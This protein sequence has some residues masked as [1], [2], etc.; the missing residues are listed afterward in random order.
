MLLW[1]GG[2]V[3]GWVIAVVGIY[4]LVRTGDVLLA[5]LFRL[6]AIGEPPGD[7]AAGPDEAPPRDG[8]VEALERIAPAAGGDE[9]AP[10]AAGQ[11]APD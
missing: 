1:I 5:D 10:G 9:A 8:D 11:G 4:L 7:V 6:D 2:A 3:V